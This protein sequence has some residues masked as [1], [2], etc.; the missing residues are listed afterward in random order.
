[1]DG[2][3][4][5]VLYSRLLGDPGLARVP[6]RGVHPDA[7]VA[8]AL[9][10]SAQLGI[11]VSRVVRR[12]RRPGEGGG[13][14]GEHWPSWAPWPPPSAATVSRR[15]RTPSVS[16]ALDGLARAEP[17]GEVLAVDGK[18]LVVSGFSKDPDATFGKVPDGWAWGYRLHVLA[19]G[20]TGRVVASCA[21]GLAAGEATVA[22]VRL[23]P[24]ADVRGRLVL[25]DANYDSNPLYATAEHRGARLR[26]PRRKPGTGVSPGHRQHA[27]RLEAIALLEGKGGEGHA[28]HVAGR[29][30]VERVLG[31]LAQAPFDLWGL[32]PF[33]RRL[34]RVRN[35]VRATVALYNQHLTSLAAQT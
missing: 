17:A 34:R 26:A 13:G 18:P 35:W 4:L 7:V 23:L 19:D 27:H 30:F 20:A 15:S 9:L 8:L 22:R 32:P 28:A 12:R 29:G 24:A 21:T 16:A 3:P 14:G 31:R 10:L 1:M 25:G 5:R 6:R 11:A 33:V 2:E